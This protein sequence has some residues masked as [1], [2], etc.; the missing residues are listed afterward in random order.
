[1]AREFLMQEG[2][3][4]QCNIRR[5]EIL[6][7]RISLYNSVRFFLQKTTWA[8]DLASSHQCLQET[9]CIRLNSNYQGNHS[10]TS[11]CEVHVHQDFHIII[12]IQIKG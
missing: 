5:L 10:P 4:I 6:F 9:W 3:V 8:L 2:T 11:I 1:M 7:D 12:C